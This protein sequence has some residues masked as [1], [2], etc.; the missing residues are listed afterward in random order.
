M[1]NEQA[2]VVDVP[3]TLVREV[4]YTYLGPKGGDGT[5]LHDVGM[6]LHPTLDTLEELENGD[7]R[8]TY[9]KDGRVIIVGP[10]WIYWQQIVRAAKKTVLA[11]PSKLKPT[12]VN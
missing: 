7:H 8:I 4:I 11:D 1:A 5:C 6:T 9:A 2:I 12:V 10:R 3:N